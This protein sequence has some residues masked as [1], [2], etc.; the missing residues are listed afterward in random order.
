V[1]GEDWQKWSQK[2]ENVIKSTKLSYFAKE[3][4][5]TVTCIDYSSYN[6]TFELQDCRILKPRWVSGDTCR[7]WNPFVDITGAPYFQ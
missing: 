3:K 1:A 7:I 6:A 5:T 4:T 2:A